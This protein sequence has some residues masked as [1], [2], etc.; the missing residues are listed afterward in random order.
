MKIEIEE[1]ICPKCGRTY[2]EHPALSRTDN[3]TLI[4]TAESERLWKAWVFP[5]K[6]RKKSSALF[7]AAPADKANTSHHVAPTTVVFDPP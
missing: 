3:K 6:N 5:R 1:R 7:T 2:T 4:L